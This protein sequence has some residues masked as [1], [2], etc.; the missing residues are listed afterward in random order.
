M[1]PPALVTGTLRRRYQRFFAEVALDDGA[2]V[3][4]HCANP[5]SMKGC[6]APGD[7]VWLSRSANPTRKLAWTW[8]LVQHDGARVCV[9][10]AVGNRVVGAALAAGAIAEAVGYPELAREV[11]FGDSRID[12][13]LRRGARR[14]DELWLEVKTAT[15]HVGAGVV[16]FP[17]AV[18]TRAVRHLGELGTLRRRGARAMLLFCVARAG[19][20]AV[21]P[22][23]EIDPAYG[24]ALRA[25]IA[26]GVEVVAYGCAVDEHGVTLAGPLPVVT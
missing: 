23:D 1:A 14:R 26:A 18:S 7:R 6:A 2:V 21:R 5:G 22:A 9:N 12:F 17:D 3:V 11:P 10:T 4:A 24:A 13:C 19:A 25:A 15:M 16:A 20:V 8:E